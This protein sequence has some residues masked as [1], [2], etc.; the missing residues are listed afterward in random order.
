MAKAQ[1][2]QSS[3]DGLFQGYS[4]LAQE[5]NSSEEK[6][7]RIPLNETY[8][9]ENHPFRVVEDE[10]M[11]EL[12]ESIEKYGILTP[13]IARPMPGG[14]YEVISG[15]RRRYAAEQVGKEDMLFIVRDYTDDEATIIMVDSNIQREDLL[16]SEKAKA[17]RMKYDAMKHQGIKSDKSTAEAVG[18]TAGDSGRTV[19]RYIRLTYLLPELLYLVDSKKLKFVEGVALSFF[20]EENQECI[21]EFYNNNGIFPTEKQLKGELSQIETLSY[22][23]LKE[24]LLEKKPEKRK[25][26]LSEK[27]LS[28]Y[29]PEEY[30]TEEI[31][32][33][34]I[35]L[36]NEWS[37]RLQ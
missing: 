1:N 11:E 15:H 34:I 31:Q 36:L 16:P 25:F 6:I 28:E 37:N 17:Y 4:E 33:V 19:Q 2:V 21:L 12:K 26:Q 24:I 18:E 5:D 32:D 22:E 3:L 14:G 10:K 8:E 30:S 7:V 20:S 29:F 9:F 35:S 13:G 27:E 23:A